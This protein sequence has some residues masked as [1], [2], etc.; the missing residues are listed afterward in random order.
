MLLWG[1]EGPAQ[2]LGGG[3]QAPPCSSVWPSGIQAQE[4]AGVAMGVAASSTLV[5]LSRCPHLGLWAPNMA[6][7]GGGKGLGYFPGGLAAEPVSQGGAVL[8]QFPSHEG[9]RAGPE[10]VERQPEQGGR[11]LVD[12]GQP[13]RSAGYLPPWPQVPHLWV[14]WWQW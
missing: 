9:G 1:R 13:C 4:E 7:G 6:G 10:V 11:L 3:R 5:D 12:T 2:G 8:A 14:G